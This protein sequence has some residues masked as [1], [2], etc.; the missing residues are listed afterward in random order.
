M[1]K[2]LGVLV[3]G[4][5]FCLG[6]TSTA[7][8][9]IIY[10]DFQFDNATP[11]FLSNAGGIF[12]AAPF[13]LAP[14]E[15]VITDIHWLGIEIDPLQD[16][17]AGNNFLVAIFQ[18]DANGLP[19]SNSPVF[20]SQPAPVTSTV[21]GDLNGIPVTGYSMYIDPLVLDPL[22]LYY[23]VVVDIVQPSDDDLWFWL[24][25][26]GEGFFAAVAPPSIDWVPTP[27]DLS[28]LLT[29]DLI[30]PEPASMTLLGLGLAGLVIGRRFRNTR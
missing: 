28:F 1:A 24:Y 29:N 5:A 10:G 19:D 7:Y 18:D 14:G 3:L 2:K 25:Q 26:G 9:D 22:N 30:V 20:V 15:N 6:L 11:S 13:V 8:G 4:V 21:V 23:L 12:A 17:Y 27:G 16:G